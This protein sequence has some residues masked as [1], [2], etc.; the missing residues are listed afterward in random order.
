MVSKILFSSMKLE[1][2]TSVVVVLL[3]K[4]SSSSHELATESREIKSFVSVNA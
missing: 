1:F 4:I 2:R 3:H